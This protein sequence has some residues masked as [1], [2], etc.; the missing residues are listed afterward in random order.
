MEQEVINYCQSFVDYNDWKDEAIKII[1][2]L[3]NKYYLSNNYLDYG[4]TIS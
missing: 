3:I 2:A 4:I 1:T